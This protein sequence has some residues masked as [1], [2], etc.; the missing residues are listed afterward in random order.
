MIHRKPWIALTVAICV[1]LGTAIALTGCSKTISRSELETKRAGLGA[2]SFPGSIVY[3]GREDDFD[4]FRIRRNI[5]LGWPWDHSEDYRVRES[6]ACVTEHFQFTWDQ[7]LWRGWPTV[8]PGKILS[9]DPKF[10]PF[11]PLPKP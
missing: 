1:T 8:T 7:D 3:R 10:Q 9:V 11:Q 5:G 2:F 6:E 4:Y